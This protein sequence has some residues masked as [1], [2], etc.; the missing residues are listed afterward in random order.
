M[1]NGVGYDPLTTWLK[2]SYGSI[3]EKLKRG[4]ECVVANN[5]VT[6]MSDDR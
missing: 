4:F 1:S 5:A 6:P 2:A 3:Q